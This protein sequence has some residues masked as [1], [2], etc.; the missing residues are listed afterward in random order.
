MS[1]GRYITNALEVEPET[2]ST[3]KRLE[4][5][6]ELLGELLNRY[7]AGHYTIREL[8]DLSGLEPREV[9]AVLD[10]AEATDTP[11]RTKQIKRN[12]LKR[13]DKIGPQIGDTLLRKDGYVVVYVGLDYV[14]ATKKGWMLEHRKVMQE[15]IGRT[16]QPHELIHHINR[17]KKDNRIENLKMLDQANHPTCLHCPYYKELKELKVYLGVN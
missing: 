13:T 10:E 5:R 3:Y 16:L 4:N 11:D 9:K 17:D 14:G 7:K 1:R 15:Y 2:Y 8:A 12:I 6:Q